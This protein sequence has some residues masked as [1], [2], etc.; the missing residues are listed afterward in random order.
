[1]IMEEFE[2]S[3]GSYAWHS[4]LKCQDALLKGVKWRV[5][6]RESIGVWSNAWLPSCD[7]SKILSPIVDG[8]EEIRVVD[9]IDLRVRQWG[10]NLFHRLFN[11]QE[12]SLI[13]SI[14]IWSANTENK[15]IWP[16]TSLGQYTV[17][18]VYRVLAK[19]NAINPPNENLNPSNE[20]WKV[21]WGLSMPNKL[22]SFLWR[23]C[24]DALPTKVN[25]KKRKVIP[26]DT[27]E[28]WMF[29]SV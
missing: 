17:Q 2:S 12:I 13:K 9:L 3:I 16:Y 14:P 8:F 10:S 25:L 4:I 18:S 19:E 1:M 23:A 24:R 7:H 6:N 5:G 11:P 21:V 26:M 15:L 20:V 22:K 28:H 29:N 27:Y